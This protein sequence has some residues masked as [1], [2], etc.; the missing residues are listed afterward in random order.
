MKSRRRNCLSAAEM[1]E[2][3]RINKYTKMLQIVQAIV[4]VVNAHGVG[5][6]EF[7]RVH[8]VQLAQSRLPP[9]VSVE[10]PAHIKWARHSMDIGDAPDLEQWL[11]RASS[12]SLCVNGVPR[13]AQEQEKLFP[14]KLSACL[15]GYA[16]DGRRQLQ[17]LFAVE[18]DFDLEESNSAFASS[19]AIVVH[20]EHDFQDLD[21]RVDFLQ[22]ALQEMK[23]RFLPCSLSSRP[24]TLLG[25]TLVN[26]KSGVALIENAK[27]LLAK[28]E[29]TVQ[30]LTPF[31]AR[32][33][34]FDKN[35]KALASGILLCDHACL[36]ALV[37]EV[38]SIAETFGSKCQ[39][40]LPDHVPTSG[41]DYVRSACRSWLLAVWP[42]LRS[43]LKPICR[44]DLDKGRLVQWVDST[45]DTW[46]RIA[47]A[48]GSVSALKPML[49]CSDPLH[50]TVVH[51]HGVCAFLRTAADFMS[52]M[53]LADVD[54][55][56]L[57]SIRNDFRT[58]MRPFDAGGPDDE[59]S[60]EFFA[61]FPD[62]FRSP[63][64]ASQGGSYSTAMKG[65]L[66]EQAAKCVKPA[67][68]LFGELWR[69][70]PNDELELETLQAMA[71]RSDAWPPANDA[72][73]KWAQAVRDD[74]LALQLDGCMHVYD[75]R[76]SMAN[77]IVL[78]LARFREGKDIKQR[79]PRKEDIDAI[80]DLRVR[81]QV[82]IRFV[83]MSPSAFD[84]QGADG[85]HLHD[86]HFD[87]VL[88]LVAVKDAAQN[89][90]QACEHK[91]QTEW[92]NDLTQVCQAIEHLCPNWQ[93]RRE[94]LL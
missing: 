57:Q 91:F 61:A 92:S 88:D 82:L 80:S 87:G 12:N 27:L 45:Q 46:G 22:Q 33:E 62:M 70:W 81:V 60:K 38:T 58:H 54:V 55:A 49:D 64:W 67:R 21:E 72:A 89:A 48:M 71:A 52:Q 24:G 30:T 5:T 51:G 86:E 7:K 34:A 56:K 35:A 85:Q 36:T 20:A 73:K 63:V 4:S 69:Q 23:S 84:A 41:T 28:T 39:D 59:A 66:Q 8:D 78:R 37:R 14:E 83:E 40:C 17:E 18:R 15:R 6:A 74:I 47:E 29:V 25:S 50:K 75:L 10:M 93:A 43:I 16:Q 76:R 79:Q 1:E 2:V 13:I 68:D 77:A 19:L 90:L 53:D 32:T 3:E 42:S 9:Q 94:T 11:E 44:T 26:F 65:I 31:R